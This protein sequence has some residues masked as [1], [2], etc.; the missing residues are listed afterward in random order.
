MHAYR[1]RPPTKGVAV[2]TVQ[3][4]REESGTIYS[5]Q[6][7]LIEAV[8]AAAVR[9]VAL[10]PSGR[11]VGGDL[12][13]DQVSLSPRTVDHHVSAVLGKL[14]VSSRQQAAAAAHR[15]GVASVIDGQPASQ[16]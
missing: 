6:G 4:V 9:A 14:A 12:Y 3:E 16:S 11:V 10:R 8:P 15:L 2:T 13:Y 7:T 5:L 1:L